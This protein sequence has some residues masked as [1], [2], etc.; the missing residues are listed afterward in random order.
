MLKTLVKT[1]DCPDVSDGFV[2]VRRGAWVRLCFSLLKTADLSLCLGQ[3]GGKRKPLFSHDRLVFEL[4]Q[5]ALK[6]GVVGAATPPEPTAAIQDSA[7]P[8]TQCAANAAPAPCPAD[9]AMRPERSSSLAPACQAAAGATLAPRPLQPSTGA[10]PA[11]HNGYLQPAAQGAKGMGPSQPSAR[12]QG[13]AQDT[14]QDQPQ[15]AASVLSKLQPPAGPQSAA[16]EAQRSHPGASACGTLQP[17]VTPQ[18]G[19]KAVVDSLLPADGHMQP[20]ADPLQGQKAVSEPATRTDSTSQPS[21]APL[22]NYKAMLEKALAW[23][24]PARPAEALPRGNLPLKR[25]AD[26]V[27]DSPES[28]GDHSA[29]RACRC[30]PAEPALYISWE[31]QQA[32]CGCSII[33]NHLQMRGYRICTL[34]CI[35]LEQ[36][37]CSPARLC[38]SSLCLKQHSACPCLNTWRLLVDS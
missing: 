37:V 18:Q 12:P 9:S 33:L 22:Q 13:A 34:S 23:T 38:A 20:L 25:R 36:E 28:L 3:M 26:E 15:P 35:F 7:G 8:A 21:V 6:A 11:L 16:L 19:H 1:L 31:L 30:V 27:E 29:K 24:P 5:H 14:Y 32:Y 10:P 2:Q 4:A 17:S